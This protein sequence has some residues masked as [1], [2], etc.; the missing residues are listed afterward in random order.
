MKRYEILDDV[1]DV[2]NTI[3]APNDEWVE[4]HFPGHWREA[5][6][7]PGPGKQELSV[8]E[9]LDYLYAKINAKGQHNAMLKKIDDAL[10]DRTTDKLKGIMKRLGIEED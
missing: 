8:R 1:G 9:E 5:P 2:V 7:N 3:N 4:E 6:L 10:E